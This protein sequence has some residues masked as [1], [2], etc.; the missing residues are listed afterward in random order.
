MVGAEGVGVWGWGGGVEE[1]AGLLLR[2][3]PET[4]H[5]P[6]QANNPKK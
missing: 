3:G 4:G 6:P 5:F 2:F 1:E